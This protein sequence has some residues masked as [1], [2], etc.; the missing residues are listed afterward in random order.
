MEEIHNSEFNRSELIE[1]IRTLR[2]EEFRKMNLSSFK[3]AALIIFII[4]AGNKLV[5][6]L[7]DIN[8]KNDSD[9][10]YEIY[11]FVFLLISI[12]IV[13]RIGWF[14]INSIYR[15]STIKGINIKKYSELDKQV[16]LLGHI[17]ECIYHIGV[18]WG[19][20]YLYKNIN[21]AKEIIVPLM[22]SSKFISSSYVLLKMVFVS[23]LFLVVDVTR[24]LLSKIWV[25]Y[26][27]YLW[28]HKEDENEKDIIAI[29][30]EKFEL[31]ENQIE[32]IRRR[33]D[34]FENK[35]PII[36]KGVLMVERFLFICL[37]VLFLLMM[38][39]GQEFVFQYANMI[40][41]C[42]YIFGVISALELIGLYTSSKIIYSW[43][44]YFE[45]NIFTENLTAEQIMDILNSE[46]IN[47]VNAELF[48]YSDK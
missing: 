30:I 5:T 19:Y 35:I 11:I 20:W 37:A 13:Y 22:D 32:K 44:E 48:Y 12:N 46:F 38:Y 42:V 40:R 33:R 39:I 8:I 18:A 31:E 36:E 43:L 23:Y 17:I 29:L 47:R 1:Y 9:K 15:Q 7:S 41:N 16:L 6:F 45:R 25:L 28:K 27:N 34:Y 24:I 10:I 21:I 14:L 2:V 26:R 3:I 4:T